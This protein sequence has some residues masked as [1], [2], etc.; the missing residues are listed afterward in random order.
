M[1]SD[2]DSAADELSAFGVGAGDYKVLATHHVPLKSR[3]Y[4]AVDMVTDRDQDFPGEM[5]ALLAPVK[6]VFEVDGGGPVFGEKFG[7]LDYC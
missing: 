4:E 3:C 7:Q 2:V 5:S 6:L 1:I